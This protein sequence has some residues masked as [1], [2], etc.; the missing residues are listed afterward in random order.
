M[1]EANT[2]DAVE[3]MLRHR[4]RRRN[5]HRSLMIELCETE[6]LA[7]DFWQAETRGDLSYNPDFQP[8]NTVG[9]K[10]FAEINTQ[11][12]GERLRI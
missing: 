6:I 1:N 11:G 8:F 12:G 4:Q 2:S 7:K 10:N 5:G 9:I 3:R